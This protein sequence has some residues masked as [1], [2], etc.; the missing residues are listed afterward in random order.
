MKLKNLA[1]L[2]AAS[3]LMLTS[4]DILNPPSETG[5]QFYSTYTSQEIEDYVYPMLDEFDMSQ[6][7]NGGERTPLSQILRRYDNIYEACVGESYPDDTAAV[8]RLLDL[9]YSEGVFDRD[10]IL[11]KWVETE[12]D[13]LELCALKTEGSGRAALGGDIVE[14]AE[15]RYN[16]RLDLYCIF[17][18]FKPMAAMSFLNFTERNMGHPIAI[19][20]NGRLRCTPFIQYPIYG[21]VID[22]RGSFTKEES[23]MLA[24]E[25][26]NGRSY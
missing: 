4:C 2:F 20:I 26:T 9:A 8:N 10:L 19:V 7:G 21:G 1:M 6:A 13:V 22:I 12:G 14:Y 11:F 17:V 23:E 24:E 16:E 3:A 25:L 18:R 5:L 15:S